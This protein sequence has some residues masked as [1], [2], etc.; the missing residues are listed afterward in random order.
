[1]VTIPD[2]DA[3]QPFDQPITAFDAGDMGCGEIVLE[4]RFRLGPLPPGA[5]LRVR[6]TDPGVRE[7][8]PAWCRMTGHTLV[9][10]SPPFYL[11]Q[12]RPT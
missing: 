4:L 5:A 10:A 11:I 12:R 2:A 7:D 9:D 8:L 1:V 3:P 6:A